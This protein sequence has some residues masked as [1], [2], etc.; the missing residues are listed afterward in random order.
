MPQSQTKSAS[1]SAKSG[2]DDKEA[3]MENGGMSMSDDMQKDMQ[4]LFLMGL[5]DIYYAEKQILRSLPKMAKAAKNEELKQAF[6]NHREQTAGQ[7]ER[8]EQVFQLLGKRAQGEQCEA[9]Q[10]ILE[11]GKEVMDEFKGREG[12]DVG[13]V[14]S[15]KAVEHYEIARYSSLKTLAKALSMDEAM[16]L[17]EQNLSEEQATDQL[18]DQC[19]ESMMQQAA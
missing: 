1:R 17:I 9:I 6:E 14:S 16:Q 3:M 11:E 15:G 18:L 10:G 5:K 19:G 13:L 8:L 7:I 12:L 2:A 4:D